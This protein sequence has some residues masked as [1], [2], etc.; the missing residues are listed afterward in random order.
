MCETQNAANPGGFASILT[1]PQREML[2]SKSDSGLNALACVT[3]T[4]ED[5]ACLQLHGIFRYRSSVNKLK[6]FFCDQP[7]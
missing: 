5:R 4:Y 1:K 7:F 6:G 2:I 3:I